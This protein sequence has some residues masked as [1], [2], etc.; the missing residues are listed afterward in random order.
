MYVRRCM[1]AHLEGMLE[2]LA[3]G[4]A[5]ASQGVC[6]SAQVPHRHD[7]VVIGHL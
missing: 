5:V 7:L 6:P 1:W 4:V 3:G 2:R